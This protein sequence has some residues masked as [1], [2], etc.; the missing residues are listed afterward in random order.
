MLIGFIIW[1]VVA[2]FL[3]G[4]GVYDLNAKK[5]VGFFTGVKPPEVKDVKKY[6]RSVGILWIVY[7]VVFEALGLPLL[8]LER[9][10]AGFLIP[11][12]LVPLA[13]IGLAV[14]YTVIMAKHKV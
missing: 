9:G 1:S 4:I 7:A 11:M 12:L 6:N 14:S 2:L 10:S 5:A 13:S 3:A 8:F